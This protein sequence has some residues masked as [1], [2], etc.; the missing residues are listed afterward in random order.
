MKKTIFILIIISILVSCKKEN[1]GRDSLP[2]LFVD[3]FENNMENWRP[4]FPQ[5]WRVINDNNDMV[6]YLFKPGSQGSLR[7][8]TSRSI[9]ES[10]DV[11]DFE[12]VVRAKCLTDTL[13]LRRDICLFFGYQDSSHYYYVH[14]SATSDKVHN[15]I[16][17]VNDAD[18]TKINPEP[19]GTSKAL[20][21]GEKW[22]TLKI[23]RKA[24]SGLIQAF[25]EDME[26]PVLTAEDKTFSH[27]KI[28]L[29]SFDDT[30]QFRKVE[31]KGHL[32]NIK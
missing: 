28:G 17:I 7:A 5:N 20:L 26:N 29:G 16:A 6:Y 27:G 3:E 30:A 25:I 22:Y 9:L 8:P 23:V 1:Q 12:L 13:N 4:N 31:L 2:L 19:P 15:V 10:Y 21:T 24:D 14:F 32:L 18:R 11:T